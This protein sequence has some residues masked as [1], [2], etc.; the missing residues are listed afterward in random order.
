MEVKHKN[1]NV[2]TTYDLWYDIDKIEYYG[3]GKMIIYYTE[4]E[5]S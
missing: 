3:N 2:S 5:D 1:Q 4:K